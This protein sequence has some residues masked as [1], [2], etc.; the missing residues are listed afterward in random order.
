MDFRWCI[1]LFWDFGD[2]NSSLGG[3]NIVH[4]YAVPGPLH[5]QPHREQ[6]CQQTDTARFQRVH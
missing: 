3:A 5:G 1:R 2:G 4:T 6:H